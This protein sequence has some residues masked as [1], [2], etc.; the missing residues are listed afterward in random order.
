[1]NRSQTPR[2]TIAAFAAGGLALVLGYAGFRTDAGGS[3][4]PGD[5]L[6]EAVRLFFLDYNGPPSPP[7]QLETAR[8]LAAGFSLLT[9]S[10]VVIALAREQT[11]RVRIRLWGARRHILL[12]G[13]G[14]RGRKIAERLKD[15]RPVA[16]VERNAANTY[17][18]GTRAQGMPTLKGDGRQHSVLEAARLTSARHVLVTVGDDSTALELLAACQRHLSEVSRPRTTV[19]VAIDD[20]ALWREL[21]QVSLAR[22][23]HPFRTEFLSIPDRVS[24][25]F[26][27]SVSDLPAATGEDRVLVYG[28][29]SIAV[30][31]VVHSVRRSKLAGNRA[32]ILLAGPHA[33]DVEA[34]LRALEPWITDV[35]DV[36][37]QGQRFFQFQDS[38]PTVALVCG[39]SEASALAA[40]ASIAR[41]VE[42]AGTPVYIAVPDKDTEQALRATDLRLE[43]VHF[44]DAEARVLGH[45]LFEDS[46]LEL[47]A[48]AKHDDYILQAH[49]RG[50]D[51]TANPSTV[52]WEALPE[53]LRESNRR[54]AESV[55]A[56]LGDLGASLTPLTG[57]VP[58][59]LPLEAKQL[60]ELAEMEHE[61]WVSDQEGDGW[62]FTSGEK[63]PERKLHPL[64]IPWSDLPDH[65]REKDRDAIRAIPAA[66][67]AVGYALKF[68]S[69]PS[70]ANSAKPT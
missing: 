42:K 25:L 41:Q 37:L 27:S 24:E 2:L 59:E 45:Q 60:D 17:V 1:M 38:S 69:V 9:V 62:R 58:D 34:E 19:H 20:L 8:F 30:R 43:S 51:E 4:S 54:F 14:E 35:A 53:S 49:G 55:G 57:A 48:R 67:A 33:K 32:S 12:I 28:C 50:I 22:E 52:P 56:K 65:E 11:Q 7:W 5:A 10:A 31:A 26:V 15:H 64:L 47:L 63:D 6:Y 21:H 16:I 36:S 61:R 40:A 66:L 46:A 70:V 68:S 39:L 13:L 3:L 18:E 23:K 44:V 29:G